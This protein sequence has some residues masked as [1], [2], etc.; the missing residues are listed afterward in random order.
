MPTE[1]REQSGVWSVEKVMA[2]DIHNEKQLKE[3]RGFMVMADDKT[4]VELANAFD[5]RTAQE[6][7]PNE[8]AA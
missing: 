8:K 1:N 7:R 6:E 4:K 5:E 3:L 2:M